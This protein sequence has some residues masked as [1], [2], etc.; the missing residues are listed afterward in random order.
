VD[1]TA[2]GEVGNCFRCMRTHCGTHA[3]NAHGSSDPRSWRERDGDHDELISARCESSVAGTRVVKRTT[4]T[5]TP[6]AATELPNPNS[7]IDA[8]TLKDGRLLL[9]YNHSAHLPQDSGWGNRCPLDIAISHDGLKWK[10]VLTLENESRRSGY[11]YPAVIQTSDGLIQIAYAWDRKM[12]K[13]VVI[14]P[15]KLDRSP[16]EEHP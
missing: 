14:D 3:H 9:V 11:A 8:V 5:W 12:I 7:G 16:D 13:H 6:L 10:H 1:E 2:F 4:R 15:Q